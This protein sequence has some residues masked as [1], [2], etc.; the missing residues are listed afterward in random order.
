[1]M[2]ELMVWG[3]SGLLDIGGG[4]VELLNLLKAQKD[5]SCFWE[6]GKI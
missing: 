4:F 6:M 2:L 1:M 5:K 3:K